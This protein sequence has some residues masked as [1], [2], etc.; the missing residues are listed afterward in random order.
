[1]KTPVGSAQPPPPPAGDRCR[2]CPT[3]G[4]RGPPAMSRLPTGT[5][6]VAVG[7]DPP[8]PWFQASGPSLLTGVT[9]R[10]L[11]SA[12]PW[13]SRGPSMQREAAAGQGPGAEAVPG[14][15]EGERVFGA[16]GEGQEPEKPRCSSE[17]LRGHT[18]NSPSGEASPSL[19]PWGPARP[20]VSR[21][22]PAD[23]SAPESRRPAVADGMKQNKAF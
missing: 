5:P 20:Q 6:G 13:R 7:W 17:V 12:G 16:P 9:H 4:W 21:Q 10:L 22:L 3:K 14:T 15:L 19:R 11:W 2:S 1:M 8:W 23:S 18:A